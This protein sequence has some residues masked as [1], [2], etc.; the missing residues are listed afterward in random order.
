MAET[1]PVSV[2]SSPLQTDIAHLPAWGQFCMAPCWACDGPISMAQ[3]R[4]TSPRP[5]MPVRD[6]RAS[7][8]M[9]LWIADLLT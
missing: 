9:R 5:S 2:P 4:V 8:L 6:R 7:F 1:C 3:T